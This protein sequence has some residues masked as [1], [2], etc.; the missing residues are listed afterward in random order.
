MATLRSGAGVPVGFRATGNP[1]GPGVMPQQPQMS[2]PPM[3]PTFNNNKPMLKAG[4]AKP[5]FD[6]LNPGPS[7]P[8]N[9]GMVRPNAPKAQ[10]ARPVRGAGRGGMIR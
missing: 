1:G 6:K 4:P 9:A 10:P 5:I 2:P 7:R 3:P 8:V